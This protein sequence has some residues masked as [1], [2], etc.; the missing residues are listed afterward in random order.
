MSITKDCFPTLTPKGAFIALRG[1][2]PMLPSGFL[3]LA[4]QGVQDDEVC[5]VGMHEQSEPLLQNLAENALLGKCLHR[6]SA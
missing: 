6:I 3:A 1:G 4:L 2:E 5:C